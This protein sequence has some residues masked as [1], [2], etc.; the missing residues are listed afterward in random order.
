MSKAFSP[1]AQS[2]ALHSGAGFVSNPECENK[3]SVFAHCIK[4][5]F[6]LR[7]RFLSP[8]VTSVNEWHFKKCEKN[9]IL[10][11]KSYSA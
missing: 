7:S 6:V 2:R 10:L 1:I 4:Q 11:A 3:Q 5:N 8:S 9:H